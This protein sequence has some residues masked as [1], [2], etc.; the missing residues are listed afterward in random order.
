[1][2]S[3]GQESGQAD[4]DLSN[5]SKLRH[6]KLDLQLQGLGRH[7]VLLHICFGAGNAA[8]LMLAWRG[9][10]QANCRCFHEL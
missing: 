9:C 3:G 2:W 7:V 6:S 4:I 5:D 10:V 1:M 8:C